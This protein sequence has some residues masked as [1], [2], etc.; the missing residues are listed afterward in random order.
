MKAEI[1]IIGGSGVYSLDSIHNPESEK[2]D[3]PYGNSP[4][5]ILGELGEGKVAFM[6]RHGEGHGTPPH[7]V[8]YR[9]NLWGLKE[10]GVKRIFATTAVGS[11]NPEVEPGEFVLLDQFLDFTKSRPLSFYEG[12]EDG[13]IHID[14]TEPY[15]PE[16]RDVLIETA[17]ELGISLHSTGTYVCTEG[18]RYE[19]A[20]EIQMFNQLGGDVVGMTNVPES[21]LARELEMCYSTVS[22]VTNF[23]AGISEEKLTPGEVAEIMD[24]NIDRVK[25]LIYSAI[26]KVPEKRNCPCSSALEGSKVEP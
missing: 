2:V 25:D 12:G 7:K 8:N 23:G 3:T 6:P 18:P 22:V 24:R 16:L 26:S 5:I 17:E 13:V 11:L 15:C 19:T 21:V 14:V 20:A 4:E 9:A 1:A 10:L